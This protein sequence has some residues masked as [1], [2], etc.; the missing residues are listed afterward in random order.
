MSLAM[1]VKPLEGGKGK[2]RPSTGEGKGE[3]LI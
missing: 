1:V 2:V 3:V